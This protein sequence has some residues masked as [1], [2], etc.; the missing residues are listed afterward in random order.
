MTRARV[1]MISSCAT[2]NP[3]CASAC[4]DSRAGGSNSITNRPLRWVATRLGA[5]KR[6]SPTP[7]CGSSSSVSTLR[8]QPPPGN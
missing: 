5:S 4:A 3:N 7:G 8:G 2:S 1:L 6:I